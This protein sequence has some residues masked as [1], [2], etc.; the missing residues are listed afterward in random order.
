MVTSLSC[1]HFFVREKIFLSFITSVDCLHLKLNLC[2]L[3]SIS[4]ITLCTMSLVVCKPPRSGVCICGMESTNNQL[5]K[6]TQGFVEILKSVKL[7]PCTVK[8]FTQKLM[9]SHPHHSQVPAQSHIDLPT[10]QPSWLTSVTYS[11][12]KLSL[13]HYFESNLTYRDND[14]LR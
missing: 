6:R 9:Q 1:K 14:N 10:P 13:I 4:S 12:E 8:K 2:L 3:P 7:K 5:G 11:L